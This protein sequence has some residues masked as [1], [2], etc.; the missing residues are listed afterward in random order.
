MA[1]LR[2]RDKGANGFPNFPGNAV[3]SIETVSGDILPNLSKV[4]E[5]VRMEYIAAHARR[6][7]WLIWRS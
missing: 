4:R 1:G 5:R 2:K 3:G 7:S 6:R